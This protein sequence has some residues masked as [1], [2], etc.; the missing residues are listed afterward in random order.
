MPPA[1]AFWSVTMCDP[2]YFFVANPM[3]RYTVSPRND[4]KRNPDG[5]LDLYIQKDSPGKAHVNNWL[6]AP[7]GGFILMMRLYEPERQVIDGTW[8]PPAVERAE[9]KPPS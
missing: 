7:D 2:E 6:P 5:S 4:L 1:K 3:N 9:A 8:S